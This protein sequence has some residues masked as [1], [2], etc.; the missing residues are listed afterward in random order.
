MW[1]EHPWYQKQQAKTL[2]V[3][4]LAVLLGYSIYF[5]I[6]G[7]WNY[8]E[9]LWAVMA[10]LTVIMSLF[11]GSTWMLLKIFGPKRNDDSKIEDDLN[12]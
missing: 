10:A 11:V 6:N 3:V 9:N 2:G 7:Y 12:L 8:L 5:V 1:E 4:L